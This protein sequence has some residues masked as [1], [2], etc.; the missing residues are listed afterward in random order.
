MMKRGRVV[1]NIKLTAIRF[2][3][4]S[5]CHSLAYLSITW[6]STSALPTSSNVALV[7]NGMEQSMRYGME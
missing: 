7:R 6:M 3:T 4:V 5:L 1:T 2:N